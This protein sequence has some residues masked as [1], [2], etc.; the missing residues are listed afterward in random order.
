MYFR[1]LFQILIQKII[2]LTQATNLIFSCMQVNK[3]KALRTQVTTM[4]GRATNRPLCRL[5]SNFQKK[6]LMEGENSETVVIWSQ[7][8]DRELQRQRKNLPRHE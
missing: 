7:S 4:L 8:Y 6:N 5:D 1:R 3:N 2:Y